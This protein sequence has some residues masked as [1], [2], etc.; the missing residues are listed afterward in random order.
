M[1]YNVSVAQLLL[2]INLTRCNSIAKKKVS[3]NLKLLKKDVMSN[4]CLNQSQIYCSKL[5]SLKRPHN[6]ILPENSW[7]S[8][9]IDQM[10]DKRS[11][12]LVR[13]KET[14]VHTEF[15]AY[16]GKRNINKTKIYNFPRLR[17]KQVLH[18][19]QQDLCALY[20]YMSRL[21]NIYLSQIVKILLFQFSSASLIQLLWIAITSVQNVLL[22][23]LDVI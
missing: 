10:I 12:L 13:K 14:D 9:R 22:M 8:R 11:K 15:D 16:G 1:L 5:L 2:T 7:L 21:R 20:K 17:R 23:H 3:V 18:W 6:R 19:A 4:S